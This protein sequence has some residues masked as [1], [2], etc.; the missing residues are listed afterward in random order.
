MKKRKKLRKKRI[1]SKII[2]S[3]IIFLIIITSALVFIEEDA[4]ALFEKKEI[5]T[6]ELKDE[7][8][9]LF[10]T[11]VHRIKTEENCASLCKIECDA[12]DLAYV[13]VS[14]EAYETECHTC[15]CRCN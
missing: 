4:I 9:L 12:Q 2:L 11:I 13:N 14:F 15:S 1:Y 6:F 3:I 7:C 10:N 8:S 5:Q